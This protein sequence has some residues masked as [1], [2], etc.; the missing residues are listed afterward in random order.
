MHIYSFPQDATLSFNHKQL[1]Y[2]ADFV[3]IP[4]R[5]Y[6]EILFAARP[7]RAAFREYFSVLD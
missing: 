2:G 6:C 3:H 7:I 4:A 5:L 1:G